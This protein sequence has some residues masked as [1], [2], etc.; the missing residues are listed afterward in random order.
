MPLTQVDPVAALVVIDLQKGVVGMVGPEAAGV[1]SKSAELARAFRERGFPVV[2]VNVTAAAPGRTDAGPFKFNFPDNWAD[3]VPELGQQPGDYV[4]SK[5]R[6]GAFIGTPLDALLRGRGVT[7]IFLTGIATSAG[8]ESTASS[9]Y[10]YGYNVVFVT[11]AMLDR[12]P[13]AHRYRVEKV[14]PRMGE[15]ATTADVLKMLEG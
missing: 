2:L 3:L 5:Q 6:R 9:A 12:D 11:D 14:F 4:V 13:E 1:V 10:D 8:V 15:T 7:Q